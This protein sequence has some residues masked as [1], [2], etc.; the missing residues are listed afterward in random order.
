MGSL[1]EKLWEIL[2]NM[3]PLFQDD[4]DTF[5]VKEG[6]LTEED[7]KKWNDI[8][9]LIKEAYKKSFSSPNE[10]LEKVKNAT[11]LLSSI[12]TKKPLP[13]E[14]KTRLEEIKGYLY[15]LLPQEAN[16]SA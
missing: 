7:V 15:S 10:C 13:P 9:K 2:N 11:E 6:Y 1:D 16:S 12:S 5:L 3:I 4:I 14:M 8:V